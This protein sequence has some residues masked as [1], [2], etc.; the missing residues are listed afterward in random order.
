MIPRCD[1]LSYGAVISQK[2]DRTLNLFPVKSHGGAG[3]ILPL[4]VLISFLFF[5]LLEVLSISAV[6]LEKCPVHFVEMPLIDKPIGI[7]A[8]LIFN[9][10]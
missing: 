1:K 6:E 9:F 8:V 7:P 5:F 3:K 2:N 10:F 4:N